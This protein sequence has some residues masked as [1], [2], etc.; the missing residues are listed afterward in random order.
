MSQ[1]SRATGSR[2]QPTVQLT[3]TEETQVGL[4]GT[5]TYVNP[6]TG[7][8]TELPL[9]YHAGSFSELLAASGLCNTPFEI[10]TVVCDGWMTET[11][12]SELPESFEGSITGATGSRRYFQGKDQT[13][14][15]ESPFHIDGDVETETAQES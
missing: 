10:P 2:F 3:L 8:V 14:F 5:Y 9:T 11:L 13:F 6:G 7:A 12:E 4:E 15:Y 1:V